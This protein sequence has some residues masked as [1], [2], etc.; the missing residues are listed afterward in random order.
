MVVKKPMDL[1]TCKKKLKAGK[2]F[3]FDRFKEDL[4]R[5]WENCRIFNQEGSEIVAKAN[6]MD[7]HQKKYLKENPIPGLVPQ[8]RLREEEGETEDIGFDQKVFLAE[9]I[10]KSPSEILIKIFNIV[11]SNSKHAVER[12]GEH[13]R[14]KLDKLDKQLFETINQ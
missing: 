6:A 1:S 8:K 7:E 3:T 4:S 2:Y 14:I 12:I 9:K 5:I 11:E 10:R 13:I